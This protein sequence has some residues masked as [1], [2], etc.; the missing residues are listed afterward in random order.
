MNYGCKVID[1]SLKFY[2]S[3]KMLV[4]GIIAFCINWLL[5]WGLVRGNPGPLPIAIMTATTVGVTF[6]M[7]I[8]ISL[9][10]V[11]LGF[12]QGAALGEA[13]DVAV[14]FGLPA[15]ALASWCASQQN[16]RDAQEPPRRKLSW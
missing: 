10:M 14:Y 8:V 3:C 6:A 11:R 12:S 13:T 4:L 7:G 5:A 15:A 16:Q 9:A 1:D 2:E